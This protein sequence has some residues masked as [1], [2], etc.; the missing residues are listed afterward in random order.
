ML[1]QR[2]NNLENTDD[3]ES[4]SSNKELIYETSDSSVVQ[5]DSEGNVVAVGEGSATITVISKDNPEITE[6]V[7]VTVVK[8][9][10]VTYE[11]IGNVKPDGITVPDEISAFVDTSNDHFSAVSPVLTRSVASPTPS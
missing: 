4:N 5:I 7:T 11:I 1:Y 3:N 8:K 6:T 10:K 2:V 9:Y